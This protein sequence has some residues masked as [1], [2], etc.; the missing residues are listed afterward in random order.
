M[1]AE[2]RLWWNDGTKNDGDGER[3]GGGANVDGSAAL[4]VHANAKIAMKVPW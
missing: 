2:G 3:N 1:V 4:E